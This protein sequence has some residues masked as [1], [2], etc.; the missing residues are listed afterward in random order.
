[1]NRCDVELMLGETH[2]QIIIKKTKQK[3]HTNTQ[4]YEILTMRQSN[5]IYIY[6]KKNNKTIKNTKE[7][8]K[9]WTQNE[10]K[11]IHVST[12]MYTEDLRSLQNP[13]W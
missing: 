12:L 7:G 13:P 6:L 10:Q 4:Q 3:K 9:D 11:S 1:M 5:N 8:R 2:P